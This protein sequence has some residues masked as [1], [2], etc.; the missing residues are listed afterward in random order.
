MGWRGRG[1]WRDPC[2]RRRLR[3]P[4]CSWAP[5]CPRQVGAESMV[6]AGTQI[7]DMSAVKHSVIGNHCQ[8]GS[9]VRGDLARCLAGLAR[10]L[11]AGALATRTADSGHVLFA[12]TSSRPP[13]RCAPCSLSPLVPHQQLHCHGPR[14]HRGRGQTVGALGLL[15]TRASAPRRLLRDAGLCRSSSTRPP[16]PLFCL[17][18]DSIALSATA[19][20]SKKSVS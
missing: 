10:A 14:G 16:Q 9:K 13:R 5:L 1:C 8:I 7:A 6:G 3:L 20:T 12:V 4:L 2:R 19:R 15:P 17:F 11:R 18:L